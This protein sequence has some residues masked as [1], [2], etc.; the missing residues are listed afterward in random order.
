MTDSSH[1][2]FPYVFVCPPNFDRLT[3]CQLFGVHEARP[4]PPVSTN[5]RKDGFWELIALEHE[6]CRLHLIPLFGPTDS[7]SAGGSPLFELFFSHHFLVLSLSHK[8]N[9]L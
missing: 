3:F 5:A 8:P 7:R 6:S 1:H 9:M 2:S 4:A